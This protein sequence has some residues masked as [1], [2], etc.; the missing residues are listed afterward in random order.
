MYD[1]TYRLVKPGPMG[2]FPR[3]YDGFHFVDISLQD[4][5]LANATI[6]RT[7]ISLTGDAIGHR[8]SRGLPAVL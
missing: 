2:E 8:L 5:E 1:N 6:V 7:S 3:A 4:V